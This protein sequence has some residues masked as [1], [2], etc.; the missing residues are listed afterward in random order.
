[1]EATSQTFRDG[2]TML[3]ISM[4]EGIGSMT[5]TLDTSDM[6]VMTIALMHYRGDAR[7]AFDALT[8]KPAEKPEDVL[9]GIYLTSTLMEL[10][11]LISQCIGAMPSAVVKAIDNAIAEVKDHDDKASE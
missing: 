2:R 8:S 5:I 4:P 11:R 1:M 6:V 3:G 9:E 10:D 7:E